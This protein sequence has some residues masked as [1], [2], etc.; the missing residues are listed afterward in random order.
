MYRINTSRH[1][2]ESYPTS[3][4][5]SLKEP[6]SPSPH[7]HSIKIG[8]IFLFLLISHPCWG[9]GLLFLLFVFQ[10][11]DENRSSAGY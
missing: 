4:I 8:G 10:L 1:P 5:G 3:Y 6:T 9:R 11:V 7:P 2:S